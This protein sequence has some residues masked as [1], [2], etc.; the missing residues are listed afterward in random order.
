MNPSPPCLANAIANLASVTVSIAADTIGMLS[1]IFLVSFV[2]NDTSLGNTCD[3]C[4][5][6]NT[7]SN[8]NPSCASFPFKLDILYPPNVLK[9]GLPNVYKNT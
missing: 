8:V 7:S 6:S 2:S 5:T 4:G 9:N 1:V 3:D